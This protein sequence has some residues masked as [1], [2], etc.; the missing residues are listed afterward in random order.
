MLLAH[1]ERFAVEH[2]AMQMY[3]TVAIANGP[4]SV[5]LPA[6]WLDACRKV[7]V[8]LQGEDHRDQGAHCVSLRLG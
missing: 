8:S 4:G 7:A 1:A 2:S 3:C 5:L 6:T